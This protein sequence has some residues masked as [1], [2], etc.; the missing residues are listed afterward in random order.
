MG[1][2]DGRIGEVGV[3]TCGEKMTIV[4]Y[5]G[6]RDID[7]Q[8]QDGTIVEHKRYDAFKTGKV[9]NPYF[10]IVYGVGYFGIGDFKSKETGKPTKCYNTWVTMHARCYDPKCQEKYP[11]Y[12][13]CRVCKE[14]NNYQEFAKW[15]N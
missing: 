8:F 4:R 2:K 7:V 3:S 6:R 14:W 11:T 12:K 1:K 5:G 9:K 10:P 13:G 15:D